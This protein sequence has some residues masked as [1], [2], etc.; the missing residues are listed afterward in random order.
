MFVHGQSDAQPASVYWFDWSQDETKVAVATVEG[1]SI[2]DSEFRLLAFRPQPDPNSWLRP[3][4]LSPDGMKLTTHNEVWDT[5]TL[6]T[7]VQI[8]PGYNLGAWSHDGKLIATLA[9]DAHSVVIFDAATGK[10]IKTIAS[11]DTYP[12]S[13]LPTWSPDGTRLAA[14]VR[15][16]G[17]IIF[18]VAQGEVSA[19]YPHEYFLQLISWSPD[20]T[21]LAY[22]EF[23]EVAP[24]TAGS[25][26]HSGSIT[27]AIRNSVYITNV[28]TGQ[29]LH[30]F[31]GLPTIGIQNLIW[32]PDGTQLLGVSSKQI[33]IWDAK[34]GQQI[35]N[36]ETVGGLTEV[37]YSPYGGQVMMGFN[38]YWY[39]GP[40]SGLTP[41]SVFTRTFLGGA[42][43]MAVPAP[44]LEKLQAITERCKAPAAV[45][46][47]LTAQVQ[48]KQ[49]PAFIQQVEALTDAQIPP[50][51]K[52]DLLAVAQ[53]LQAKQ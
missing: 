44:S 14:I 48:A 22:G 32:S 20:G 15:G 6:Q 29:I 17:V 19:R 37:K 3:A 42:I 38:L 13:F 24:G 53:A 25:I 23:G 21:R 52:A 28:A 49:L 1:I 10:L 36:Y 34:S 11:G 4:G 41:Q 33:Y 45:Q 16:R 7:L 43:Q 30:T 27:G 18:D 39:K 51:C 47:A 50:G 9:P 35:S 2:Y 8:E 5:K 46:Q 12:L 40:S 31:T 26:L